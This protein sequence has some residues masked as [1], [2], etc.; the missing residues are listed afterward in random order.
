[1]DFELR[2]PHT[3]LYPGLRLRLA[4]ERAF[5]QTGHAERGVDVAIEFSDGTAARA[6]LEPDGAGWTL[7][8]AAHR[9]AAGTRIPARRWRL[10]AEHDG[11]GEALLRIVARLQ[12]PPAAG[13]GSS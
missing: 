6:R 1:M 7:A 3:H 11:A 9:T 8:V 2:A 5:T 12:A 4:P 13:G 10:S